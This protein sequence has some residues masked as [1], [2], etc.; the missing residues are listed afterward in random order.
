MIDMKAYEKEMGKTIEALQDNLAKVRAGRA[1]PNILDD[2]TFSYYG[3]E[4]KLNQAAT[5]AVPEARLITIQPWDKNNLDPI[6]KAILAS[7]IGITPSN[8]G[9]IIRLPFPELTQERRE[10]LVKEVSELA[11]QTKISVRNIRRDAMEAVKKAEKNKEITED[12]RYAEEEDIQKLT[13][14]KIEEVEKIFEAKKK[15]LMEI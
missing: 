1:N 11:E 4:T 5:I 7:N 14:K 6:E 13:D 2:I 9:K 10:E 12:D 15:D 8:D 3:V